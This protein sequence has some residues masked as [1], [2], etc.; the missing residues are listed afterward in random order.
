ME[1]KAPAFTEHVKAGVFTPLGK[2]REPLPTLTPI[3]TQYAKNV[4]PGL[5]NRF[6]HVTGK[7]YPVQPGANK[8]QDAP[9]E[10]GSLG[11]G[12]AVRE[13]TTKNIA[14]TYELRLVLGQEIGKYI[15]FAGN[16]FFDQDLEVDREREIGFSTAF[17]Y[18]I[19][20]EAFEGRFGNELSQRLSA[21]REE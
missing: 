10:A 20:G 6:R 15:E 4:T 11:V 2:S 18:A 17:S 13:Q 1:V 14:D 21:R 19:R 8:E 7:Q 3:V 16:I 12:D 5:L 9:D